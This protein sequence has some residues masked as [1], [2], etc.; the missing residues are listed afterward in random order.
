MKTAV[1]LRVSTTDQEKG[2]E[3]QREALKSYCKNHRL[4][5]TKAHRYL[6]RKSGENDNRPAFKKLQQAIF[7]GEVDTVV[8]WKLDRISR[9]LK[10]GV[11]T[12][13]D[14][15]DKDIKVISVSQQLDFSGTTGKIVMPV[16]FAIADMERTNIIENTIRGLQNAKAKG[17]VLGR[18]KKLKKYDAKK[19]QVM[20]DG[21][22]KVTDIAR[23]LNVS[24]Q[25]VYT[26]LK[27][28][29]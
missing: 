8:V 19:I 15:L 6:D 17:V 29:A 7:N 24:R 21:G 5:V 16:L 22:T 18:P 9:S 2:L 13:C 1:Y 10:H 25:T 20:K 26:A 4:K 23:K 28:V 3:S 14:W 11:A 27:E 12:L